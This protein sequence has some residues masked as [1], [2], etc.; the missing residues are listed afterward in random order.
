MSDFY[1]SYID[2]IIYYIIFKVH[3][4]FIYEL[5]LSIILKD[6]NKCY[7][8]FFNEYLFVIFIILIIT[9]Y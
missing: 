7:V 2:R 6:K 5:S 9:I 8:L 3:A 1:M 4:C